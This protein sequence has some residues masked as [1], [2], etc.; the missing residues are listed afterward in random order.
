MSY[1]R[2][3]WND[4]DVYVF[5]SVYGGI[6]CCGC[7]LEGDLT[8]NTPEEM[9]EHLMEHR[10][11]GHTVPE[12]ALERL[13]EEAGLPLQHPGRDWLKEQAEWC[14][15]QDDSESVQAYG[16]MLLEAATPSPEATP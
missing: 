12:F 15:R 2:F 8:V 1:C 16:R 5:A 7:K 4:S 14:I 13:R 6:E 9:I 10:E 11:A 3:W